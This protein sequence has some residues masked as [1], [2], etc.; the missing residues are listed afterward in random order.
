MICSRAWAAHDTLSGGAGGDHA[1]GRRRVRIVSTAAPTFDF[2]SYADASSG[3][4]VDLLE[5]EPATRA[6]RRATV[7]ISIEGLTGSAH[8]DQFY[9]TA[10]WDG[11]Y[12]GGGDDLLE[13]RGG[14]DHARRRRGL[15]LCR[16][17]GRGVR[18]VA[19]L[20][21]GTG[22]AGD[23]AGDVFVSIEGLQGS[24]Y[25]DMLTG[26]AGATRSTAGAAATSSHGDL[27]GNDYIEGGD[28]ADTISGGEGFDWLLGN[29]GR[30]P[31]PVRLNPWSRVG[32]GQASPV[33]TLADFSG[34]QSDRIALE[35]SA[36]GLGAD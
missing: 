5:H 27:S 3:V 6:R 13:G 35:T 17:L 1:F 34:A 7:Y 11:F 20:A 14:G 33:D 19:S 16:L 28:G 30:G 15:R 12:G 18:R 10:G 32:R 23:A 36:F 8:S 25:N 2:A 31:V 24:N 9:G 29:A 22:T 26:N 4:L 21:T